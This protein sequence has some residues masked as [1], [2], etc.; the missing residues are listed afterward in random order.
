MDQARGE[1]RNVIRTGAV[2]E[3]LPVDAYL[4]EI[5]A[6]IAEHNPYRQNTVITAIGNGSA[7]RDVVKRYAKEL[8]YLGLWMTPEFALLIANAPD[9][10]RNDTTI[11][12]D[13]IALM[14]RQ[15]ARIDELERLGSEADAFFRNLYQS[16]PILS[17]TI[18]VPAGAGKTRTVD[19]ILAEANGEV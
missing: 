6:F 13:A 12:A 2:D 18:N 16:A 8:Y 7:S 14:A 1:F 11:S 3:A 9:A 19:Q 4:A 5:D 10:L 17:A 15:A